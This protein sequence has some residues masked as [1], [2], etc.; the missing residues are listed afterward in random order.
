[1]GQI[2]ELVNGAT[3]PGPAGPPGSSGALTLTFSGSVAFKSNAYA[4]SL[5]ATGG[6]PA[7]T[8]SISSGSLPTG[9][10]LNTTTGAITGTPTVNG[11]VSFT[12]KVT[13]SVSAT[14][15]VSCTI[16]VNA[17][18]SAPT[19][20]SITE[21][22]PRTIKLSDQTTYTVIE[23]GAFESLSGVLGNQLTFQ[24]SYDGGTTWTTY[25]TVPPGSISIPFRVTNL[26]IYNVSVKTT[27][28]TLSVQ[29]W[30][31][32]PNG[33]STITTASLALTIE[34]I[35]PPSAAV[36]LSS[37]STGVFGSGTSGTNFQLAAANFPTTS[38]VGN[39]I[40][41]APSTSTDLSFG[42]V[43]TYNT[44]TGA[45]TVTSWN[46]GSPTI[47]DS[48]QIYFG[49]A[50]TVTNIAGSAPTLANIY[51]G[52]NG[53]GNPY[54]G[55]NV[56]LTCPGE[57]DPD[58][59][60]YAVWIEWVNSSGSPINPGGVSNTSGWIANTQ[61]S[62]DGSI[63]NW[64]ILGNYPGAG[65]DGYI[66]LTIWAISRSATASV[67]PYTGDVNCVIQ[68]S[69]TNPGNYH[70]GPPPA[71]NSTNIAINPSALQP[72]GVGWTPQSAG[73]YSN[74]TIT[75]SGQVI[76]VFEIVAAG[77]TG[78]SPGPVGLSQAFAVRAGNATVADSYVWEVF[79]AIASGSIGSGSV[80]VD[81]SFY[82]AVGAQ[83]GSTQSTSI[84]GSL[85]SS[86]LPFSIQASVP[87]GAVKGI[88]SFDCT[89]VTATLVFT[90][91][92]LAAGN[93]APLKRAGNNWGL[94]VG[95]SLHLNG[96]A[97][98][99]QIATSQP[100]VV[101][102]TGL[103]LGPGVAMTA[104]TTVFGYSLT[105]NFVA[106]GAAGVV[107]G[108]N[109]TSPVNTVAISSNGM[110]IA[111]YN[112][113]YGNWNIGTAYSVGTVVNYAILGSNY[114]NNYICLVA[115]TGNSPSYNSTYWALVNTV[116]VTASSVGIY[117]AT[118]SVVITS[119]GMMIATY[120]G[121]NGPYVEITT[122][123]AT[124]NQGSLVLTNSG[125][126]VNIESAISTP[127]GTLFGVMV[128][129]GLV[130]AIVNPNNITICESAGLGGALVQL[131]PNIVVVQD[132][133]GLHEVTIT[134]TGF[135][136]Q[137]GTGFTGTLA[138]AISAGKNVYGGFIY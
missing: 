105:G 111:T 103:A 85:T 41:A 1:M 107:I 10:S 33:I 101:V 79:A 56:S 125:S 39:V 132:S 74:S 37:S 42:V 25:A 29:A 88:V 119:A 138:A 91:A 46:S 133:S 122:S 40:A 72:F 108:D 137:L 58:A 2:I 48:Y 49:A 69:I 57:G 123:G 110:S 26:N 53:L 64:Q 99:V 83:V 77:Q 71:G 31:S 86:L 136:C 98:E 8:F 106:T 68:T 94:Q 30:S 47:N 13:D 51:M 52:I 124:I 135:S 54:W 117:G 18:T 23:V 6:T 96:T 7:Y 16:V 134:G 112:P 76:D 60:F 93:Q 45:G 62:N 129:N 38:I 121:T 89:G 104:G 55:L 14:A 118:S 90:N 131:S 115:N 24:L 36:I 43:A 100:F 102:A 34:P 109:Y 92:Y 15:T 22:G 5:I 17:P 67:A 130:Y 27:S 59:W 3:S 78:T 9:L 63:H 20:V 75:V 97:L 95:N 81:L 114:Y 28:Q 120:M 126:T 73:T 113:S 87:T 44:S 35:Q 21:I 127:I 50:V 19:S 70:I 82:N 4:A 66:N 80:F 12:G 128:N 61:V 11:S 84:G 116:S 65:V 32:G